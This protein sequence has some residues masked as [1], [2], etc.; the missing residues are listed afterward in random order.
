MEVDVLCLEMIQVPKGNEGSDGDEEESEI[1]VSLGTYEC[2]IDVS[3][4][5]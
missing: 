2:N 5:G 4:K 1:K 3:E